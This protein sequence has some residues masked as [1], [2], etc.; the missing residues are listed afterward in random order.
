MGANDATALVAMLQLGALELHP[1]GSQAP[2][3]GFPDRL[4]FDLDPADDVGF[5]RLVEAAHLVKTL[6]E[7]IGLTAFVKTTGGKGLHVVLPTEPTAPWEP[8]QAL[9]QAVAAAA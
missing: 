6:L 1:W 3:L 7:N 4:I 2:K 8:A 9:T 5:E